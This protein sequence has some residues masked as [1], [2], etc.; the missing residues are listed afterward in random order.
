VRATRVLVI[1]GALGLAAALGLALTRS[2]GGTEVGRDYRVDAIFD[3]AKGIIPGQLVK[4]AGTRVGTVAD[5]RLTPDYKARIQMRVDPRFAP[6]RSDARCSI[7]PEGLI[8][9]NFVQCDPGT[10]AGRELRGRDGQAP[11]VPVAN[12]SVPINLTDLFNV[13]NTPVRQRFSVIVATLGIGSAAR[14]GD[15]NDVIR[16]ANPTLALVRRATAILDRQ[17]TQLSA[18]VDATDR[19]VGQLT[20]RRDRLQEI[21]DRAE[22]VSAVT[23]ERRQALRLGIRRLPP[24]LDE[25]RPLAR[26]LDVLTRDSTPVLR[27]LRGAMPDLLRLVARVEPAANAGRPVLGELHELAVQGRSTIGKAEPT[28]ERARRLANALQPTGRTS[29][30]L[31]VNLKRQGLAENLVE[32]AYFAT[33][34]TARFDA[35]GHILPAHS[36]FSSACSPFAE[37]PV[38]GCNTFYRGE[39]TVLSPSSLSFTASDA[40]SLG[41]PAIEERRRR[42]GRRSGR[43]RE[44]DLA[45]EAAEAT[46]ATDGAD[47]GELL[48]FLLGS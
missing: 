28:V 12:N 22:S 24:L 19:V 35:V 8:A 20:T 5:V 18:T 15:V 41:L 40:E 32:F 43:E 33:A 46:G 13:F 10:P 39:N 42:G 6:F 26:R 2:G 9:E 29:T 45:S 25:V 11:T 31:L 7:Q 14:G 1:A 36:F 48:D 16:R 37:A 4:I 17:R 47:P 21:V 3:T 44:D 23:A 38:D 30:E 34:G 27:N